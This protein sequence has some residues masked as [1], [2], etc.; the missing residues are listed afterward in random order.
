MK[1]FGRDFLKA[2]V[3]NFAEVQ[4]AFGI[5]MC[6]LLLY[7]LFRGRKHLRAGALHLL[8]FLGA[9]FAY[10]VVISLAAWPIDRYYRP[11]MPMLSVFAAGG[12][13]CVVRDVRKRRVGIALVAGL[14]GWYLLVGLH[15]P[16]RAHRFEQVVAGR[17]L[18]DHDP[19]YRG[20]VVSSYSQTVLYAGM[21]F[22]DAEMGEE[23]LERLANEQRAPKYC[24]L[25]RHA[26]WQYPSLLRF[27]SD[28][29]WRLLRTFPARKIRIWRN[30]QWITRTLALPR[31]CAAGPEV[32]VIAVDHRTTGGSG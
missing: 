11:I 18:A 27:L 26:E 5:A 4:D 9:F 3:Q 1:E 19:T 12:L 2:F 10:H 29:H 24:M 21:Q 17:W 20:Y 13:F 25:E 30:S 31:V 14:G 6:L 22:L 8:L 23:R 15:E 7:F 16:I 32:G 28:Y